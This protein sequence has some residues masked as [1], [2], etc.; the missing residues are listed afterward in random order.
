MNGKLKDW[1]LKQSRTTLSLTSLTAQAG[2]KKQNQS[3]A[4]ALQEALNTN[5]F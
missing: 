4:D 2:P 5:C 1:T 3:D